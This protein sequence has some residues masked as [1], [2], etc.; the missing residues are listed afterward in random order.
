MSRKG[1][2]NNSI[3]PKHQEPISHSP[4]NKEEDETQA[5][6]LTPG[7]RKDARRKSME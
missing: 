3:D 4:T 5:Q 7:A 1:L 2:E 6:L